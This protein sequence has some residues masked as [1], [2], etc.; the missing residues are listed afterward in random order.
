MQTSVLTRQV[1]ERN[2]K[3]QDR[4]RAIKRLQRHFLLLEIVLNGN[5][6]V[7]GDCTKQR[8]FLLIEIVLKGNIFVGGDCTNPRH[9]VFLEILPN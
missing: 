3:R 7:G 6:F 5:I 4:W 8:H 2:R 1:R 9:F